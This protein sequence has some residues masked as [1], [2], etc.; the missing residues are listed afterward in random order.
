M[1]QQASRIRSDPPGFSPFPHRDIT[2]IAGL[3][4][5]EITFLLDEAEHWITVNRGGASSM[6]GAWPA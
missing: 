1:E 5:H 2:G 3:Q 4:P 6:M